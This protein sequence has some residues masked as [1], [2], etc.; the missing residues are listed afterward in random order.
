MLLTA[1]ANRTPTAPGK[2]GAGR[3]ER[4]SLL[5]PPGQVR[6]R[7]EMGELVGIDHTVE[8]LDRAVGDVELDHA[9]HAPGSVVHHGTGLAVDPGQPEGD[10]ESPAP[11]EQGD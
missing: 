4:R 10:A 2:R 11:A 6:H 7:S 5:R 8:R 1:P 3:S 9:D